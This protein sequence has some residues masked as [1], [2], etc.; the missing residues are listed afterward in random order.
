MRKEKKI[1][2]KVME[3]ERESV[4][5]SLQNNQFSLVFYFLFIVTKHSAQC[6]DQKSSVSLYKR[7]H[8]H[9]K[10]IKIISNTML[11]VYVHAYMDIPLEYFYLYWRRWPIL[12][13]HQLQSWNSL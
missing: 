13:V 9:V 10:S 5:S 2:E 7:E 4:L 8:L 12:Y 6:H 3:R 1:E 11:H